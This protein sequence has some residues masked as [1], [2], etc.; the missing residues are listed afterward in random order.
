MHAIRVLSVEDDRADQELTRR[1]LD[2]H[3]PPQ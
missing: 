3:A 1:H 2:R